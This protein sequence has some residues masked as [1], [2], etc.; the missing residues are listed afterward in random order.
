MDATPDPVE[1]LRSDIAVLRAVIDDALD[2]GAGE[3]VLRRYA[4]L[5]KDQKARLARLE[6]AEAAAE[7]N[8]RMFRL[9]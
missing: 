8:R 7:I 1:R 3:Y 2:R 5:L 6:A 9:R 4:L